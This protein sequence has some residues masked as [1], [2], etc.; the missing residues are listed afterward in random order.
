MS[1]D[2]K[3]PYVVMLEHFRNR[4]KE[5]KNNEEIDPLSIDKRIEVKVELSWGGPGDG[6]KIYLDRYTREPLEGLYYYADWFT[7]EE[8]SLDN[9]EL[10]LVVEYFGICQ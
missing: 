4:V 8:Q 1:N 3:H 2:Q 6:F 10:Q 5:M 9:E 7:C